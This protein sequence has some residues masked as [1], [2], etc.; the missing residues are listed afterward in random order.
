MPLVIADRIYETS[1][2]TGTGTLTLDGAI[3]GFRSF[4]NGVGVTNSTYYVIEGNSEWEIGIGTVSSGT[5]SRDTVLESSNANALVSFSAGLKKVFSTYPG[6]K[7]VSLDVAQTLTNKTL[8]NP[9]ITGT[10]LEDIF[11]LTDS[12]TVDIVPANGSIQTLTLAGTGR[13]LTFSTMQNGE[14]VTLMINDGSSGTITTWNCTFVNNG[15]AAPSPLSPSG[16]TVVSIWKVGGVV[17]AAV[18][19]NV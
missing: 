13:T 18:V 15:G 3:T 8:T 11:P 7:A 17:Y 4:A 9:A 14:A 6:D 10:I 5:L 12:S 2:T 16:Y 1:T 19:G